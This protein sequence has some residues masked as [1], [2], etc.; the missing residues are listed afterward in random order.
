[1][2]PSDLSLQHKNILVVGASRGIG[3]D[4]AIG[5]QLK[6]AN[7]S[8]I[9]RS[10]ISKGNI[11]FKYTQCDI[12]KTE[13]LIHTLDDTYKNFQR[14]DCLVNVAGISLESDGNLESLNN[15]MRNSFE[16]NLFS[17]ANICTY[18][19]NKMKE[20]KTGGSIVN[21]SSIG[22]YLAFPNNPSYQASKS[23]LE[24]FTRS[25]AYDYGI[26]NIRA[27]SIA[28]G[29]FRTDMTQRSWDDPIKREKRANKTL[30]KRWGTTDEIIGPCQLLCSNAG[31]YITGSTIVIDGGWM[32]NGF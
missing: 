4:I 25:I 28:L 14:I 11:P 19:A 26:Y 3:K 1:M 20:T 18:M 15:A 23:A 16:T 31:S 17:I 6:G 2:V 9:G 29:Y 5:L 32:A 24:A 22:A 13:E 12:T 27:N 7:V 21:I 8:G 10:K 30:L